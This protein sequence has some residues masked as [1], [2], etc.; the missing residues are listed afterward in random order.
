MYFLHFKK[1]SWLLRLMNPSGTAKVLAH[2]WIWFFYSS[3]P[4]L[5][6]S[7]HSFPQYLKKK[8]SLFLIQHVWIFASQKSFLF[9]DYVVHNNCRYW[10]FHYFLTCFWRWQLGGKGL[11]IF[12]T[13]EVYG[14]TAPWK[15]NQFTFSP[16]SN[17]NAPFLKFSLTLVL[18]FLKIPIWW[19]KLTSHYFNLHVLSCSELEHFFKVI[20]VIWIVFLIFFVFFNSISKTLIAFSWNMIKIIL[21]YTNIY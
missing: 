14:Q 5:P 9:S 20:L 15:I 13:W 16:A 21:K 10:S 1:A 11:N 2:K 8:R 12:N 7:P 4:V 18:S 3:T 6:P 19:A 17:G